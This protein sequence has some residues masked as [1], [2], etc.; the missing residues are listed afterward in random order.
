M[1]LVDPCRL[2]NPDMSGN[3]AISAQAKGQPF[4]IVA[5]T[6]QAPN[7][8]MPTEMSSDSD[9]SMIWCSYVCGTS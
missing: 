6:T 8:M 9:L 3:R 7:V 2:M 4:T 1:A 5:A